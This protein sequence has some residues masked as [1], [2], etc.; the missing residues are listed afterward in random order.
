MQNLSTAYKSVQNFWQNLP[1]GYR[2][3]F[4]GMEKDDE[5]K[6][7]EGSS[8]D[9]GARMYDPRIGR[10]LMSDPLE[11]YFPNMSPYNFAINNPIL[12]TDSE[13]ESAIVTIQ[14]NKITVTATLYFYGNCAAEYATGIT[15]SIQDNWNEIGVVTK[16]GVEYE[17]EFVITSV[18]MDKPEDQIESEIWSNNNYENNY[19]RVE[20]AS[21]DE[22]GDGSNYYSNSSAENTG[23]NAGYFLIDVPSSGQPVEAIDAADHEFGH[24]LGWYDESQI[25]VIEYGGMT[26]TQ[27]D[28]MHDANKTAP[29]IMTSKIVPF[30]YPEGTDYL[31]PSGE[32]DRSQI[33]TTG[34]DFLKLNIDWNALI[35]DGA[36]TVG[37]LTN[38]YYMEN[39]QVNVKPILMDVVPAGSIE[40]EIGN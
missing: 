36:T 39:G 3:R 9:F 33:C 4:N 1:G 34:E 27:G 24:G 38:A 8:Y 7:V 21:S 23:G 31:L 22:V 40:V 16:D 29:G 25:R 14:G 18:V 6:N 35:I 11:R 37:N 2:Y 26:Y 19:I 30:N 15:N 12:A 5:I 10:W 20:D 17:V 13:G 32:I 28:P